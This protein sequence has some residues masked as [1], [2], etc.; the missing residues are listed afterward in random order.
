MRGFCEI[1]PP[2]GVFIQYACSANDNVT[3]VLE[4]NHHSLFTKRLLETI[5]V[6]DECVAELFHRIEEEVYNL[7]NHAHRPLAMN[8][9]LADWHI[10]FNESFFG[11]YLAITCLHYTIL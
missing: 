6:K 2:P 9:L 10:V 3:D 11:K 1:K 5:T 4:T 7:R 8:G